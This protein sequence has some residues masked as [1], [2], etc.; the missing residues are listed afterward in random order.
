MEAASAAISP[1]GFGLDLMVHRVLMCMC[2]GARR[3]VVVLARGRPELETRW[4]RAQEKRPQGCG[5]ATTTGVRVAGGR[6]RAIGVNLDPSHSMYRGPLDLPVV[7]PS[8][9][10]RTSTA[11]FR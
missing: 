7:V 8:V 4:E 6:R 3:G 11:L 9:V 1:L 2:G 10:Q 5:E